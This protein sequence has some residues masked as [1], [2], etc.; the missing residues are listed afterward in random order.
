M[1]GKVDEN[2]AVL[3]ADIFDPEGMEQAWSDPKLGKRLE[4]M[5]IEHRIYMLQPAPVPGS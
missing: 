4:E 5:G 3:K 1:V 2:I